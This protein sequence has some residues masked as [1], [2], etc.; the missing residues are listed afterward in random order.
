MALGELLSSGNIGSEFAKALAV[1]APQSRK[2]LAEGLAQ[3]QR[4]RYE[5]ARAGIPAR[6]EIDRTIR[7]AMATI[8]N[9]DTKVLPQAQQALEEFNEQ[10]NYAQATYPDPQ[11]QQAFIR[12]KFM[13]FQNKYVAIDAWSRNIKKV[14]EAAAKPNVIVPPKLGEYLNTPKAAYEDDGLSRLPG[15]ENVIAASP[16][17]NNVLVVDLPRSLKLADYDQDLLESQDTGAFRAKSDGN[18]EVKTKTLNG[19]K[20]E[21]EVYRLSKAAIAD[22]VRS[23]ASSPDYLANLSYSY[24]EANRNTPGFKE[25]VTEL[26]K[27]G[28]LTEEI[29]NFRANQLYAAGVYKESEMRAAPPSVTN[30]NTY[31]GEAQSQTA[32]PEAPKYTPIQITQTQPDGSKVAGASIPAIGIPLKAEN[33]T[34][35]TVAGT[36]NMDGNEPFKL[37]G[38]ITNADASQLLVVPL[39]KTPSKFEGGAA[40]DVYGKVIDTPSISTELSSNNVSFGV[41]LQVSSPDEY[42]IGNGTV[43]GVNLLYP[44]QDSF[45]ANQGVGSRAQK[46]AS[47]AELK[48]TAESYAV[49]D[50]LNSGDQEAINIYRQAIAFPAVSD[51]SVK[52]VKMANDKGYISRYVKGNKYL[53]PTEYGQQY[54]NVR[55]GEV[56]PKAKT[57]A[58]PTPPPSNAAKGPAPQTIG[59]PAPP[60]A[61]PSPGKGVSRRKAGEGKAK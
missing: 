51:F 16:S 58:K 48:A 7:S 27:N 6:N 50:L 17:D 42:T 46:A 61:A 24:Y 14:R 11:S 21:Y 3:G 53:A 15:W 54:Q 10:V 18:P 25:K 35:A 39:Y 22:Q 20:F 30:I 38:N 47:Q 49:R 33:L 4:R 5:M 29:I 32:A 8:K 31:L 34:L 45:W 41:Y 9:V 1:K 59:K 60:P 26:E 57:P 37:S 12:D 56:K 43:K 23:S 28:K 55:V 40:Y 36:I 19:T 52:L 13:E 2:G 44:A